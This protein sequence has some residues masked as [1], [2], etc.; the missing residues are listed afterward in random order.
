M[1]FSISK[2]LENHRGKMLNAWAPIRTR[3]LFLCYWHK[4][5]NHDVGL[6]C[7]WRWDHL[8]LSHQSYRQ[9]WMPVLVALLIIKRVKKI[10]KG[11]ALQKIELQRQSWGPSQKNCHNWRSTMAILQSDTVDNIQRL[12]ACPSLHSDAHRSPLYSAFP[13]ILNKIQKNKH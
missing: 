8:L 9:L 10:I 6:H 13:L 1:K 2:V 11:E 4:N 7:R 3:A 12:S 5:M